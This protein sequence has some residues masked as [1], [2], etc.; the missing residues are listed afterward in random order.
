MHMHMCPVHMCP[1]HGWVD[2]GVDWRWEGV[3]EVESRASRTDSSYRGRLRLN[4]RL[5]PRRY[6][7]AAHRR[8]LAT[9]LFGGLRGAAHEDARGDA[10]EDPTD[11][12]D[13]AGGASGEAN[14]REDGAAAH[15]RSG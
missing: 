13:D 1:V 3:G 2:L 15:T 4:I 5:S 6:R 14:H 8:E 10:C 9:T 11:R 12:A 7:Q